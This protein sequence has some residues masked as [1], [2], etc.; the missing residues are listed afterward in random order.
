M[1]GLEYPDRHLCAVFAIVE[2]A[3]SSLATP[4]NF[5]M[6]GGTLLTKICD[7]LL[8]NDKIISIF[9]DLFTPDQFSTD[10][11][12]TTLSYYMKVFGNDRAKDMCYR[13]K[14]NIT[15]GPT[16]G[17]RATVLLIKGEGREIQNYQETRHQCSEDK[18][19]CVGQKLWTVR[20]NFD[21]ESND[22]PE[23]YNEPVVDETTEHTTMQ[24]IAD[25]EVE[26]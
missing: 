13:F 4:V 16:V 17:L 8:G 5:T 15:N 11:L 12:N 9:S 20:I 22:E 7:A 14:S 25:Q 1:G 2:Q 10:T 24:K 23:V 18:R 19:H 6:F 21:D 3:Y 26:E